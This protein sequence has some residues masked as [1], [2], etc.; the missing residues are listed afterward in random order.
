MRQYKQKR[1]EEV[2]SSVEDALIMRLGGDMYTRRDVS[3][4]RGGL[5]RGRAERAGDAYVGDGEGFHGGR[6]VGA[7]VAPDGNQD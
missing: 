4:A 5:A 1:G 7:A 2:T 6:V 3:V